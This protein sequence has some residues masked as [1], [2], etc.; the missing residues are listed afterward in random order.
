MSNHFSHSD[1]PPGWPWS[2]L[3]VFER[4]VRL[5]PGFL[6]CCLAY[7]PLF[8]SSSRP[9]ALL[10]LA[11][12]HSSGFILQG[13]FSP[14]PRQMNCNPSVKH[15]TLNKDVKELYLR[16]C[17]EKWCFGR[18]AFF[19]GFSNGSSRSLNSCTLVWTLLLL[20]IKLNT[21]SDFLNKYNLKGRVSFKYQGKQLKK[22]SL[23]T[24][25]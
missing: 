14:N 2:E 3:G 13:T 21:S 8:P 1:V 17:V 18:I 20:S 16:V 5:S 23:L 24:C 22:K 7:P 4:R 12:L 25:F 15:N 11:V 19:Y 6:G 10:R 9:P